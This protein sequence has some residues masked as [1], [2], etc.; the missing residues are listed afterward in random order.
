MSV[1]I[2]RNGLRCKRPIDG[3]SGF[4]H[5]TQN[6]SLRRSLCLLRK[7]TVD[8]ETL[9]VVQ[10]HRLIDATGQPSIQGIS[11]T[12]SDHQQVLRVR[13]PVLLIVDEPFI[14]IES[15]P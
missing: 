14:P 7:Y 13:H 8:L 9:R 10:E 2:I 15:K 6:R 1:E 5:F 12:R 11:I 4:P 3:T